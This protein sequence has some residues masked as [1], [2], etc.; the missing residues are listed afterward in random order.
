MNSKELFSKFSQGVNWNAFLYFI[1]KISA[2]LLTFLLYNKLDSKTFS[3]FANLNAIIFLML[4]WI[5]F[6]FQKS[7][8]RF[9]P[10][11]AQNS[12]DLKTFI[13]SLLRFKVIVLVVSLPIYLI[14]VNQL[15]TKL[16]LSAYRSYFYAGAGLVLLEG[17]I[18]VIR[19]IYHA[20][21]RQKQFN[22]LN[23]IALMI[24][25]VCDM[26]CICIIQNQYILLA[27]LIASKTISRI[28]LLLLAGIKLPKLYAQIGHD[29][30]K[31]IHIKA[32]N[33]KFVVH[34]AIM[35]FNTNIKSLTERNVLVPLFTHIFG[36]ETAN[37]FKVANDGALLFYRI[38]I[39][40]IGTT[41]TALFAHIYNMKEG[42]QT[43][44]IAFKKLTT[45]IAALVL[46]L[47][48]IVFV[49][50][51]YKLWFKYDQYVFQI[52]LLIC[53]CLLMEV[54]F[55]PYERILEVNRRYVLLACAYTPYIIMVII[56]LTTNIMT[57]IGLFNSI[58]LIHGVRLVSSFLMFLITRM[59]YKLTFP[60]KYVC[61]LSLFIYIGIYMLDKIMR[62]LIEITI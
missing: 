1:Y 6:G 13:S 36:P 61:A 40:S 41:D 51:R 49:L 25:V 18:S 47:L 28:I 55:S 7:I 52:F 5:D 35:W 2:T 8:A 37:I 24:E 59:R 60:I 19:L 22:S 12:H 9:C 42:K 38:V 43:W 58:T 14:L 17:L 44:Q 56:L 10:E 16:H 23:A 34:S 45:K 48:G 62:Y 32:L 54:M 46:P 33:K 20:Y 31:D 27:A 26:S 4:L 3:T 29:N 39:K 57:Y 15:S 30:N 50:Y 21:F 53:I 11:Y